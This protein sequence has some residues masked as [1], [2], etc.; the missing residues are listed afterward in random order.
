MRLQLKLR[1]ALFVQDMADDGKLSADAI[2]K[3]SEVPYE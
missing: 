1:F 3:I 2:T